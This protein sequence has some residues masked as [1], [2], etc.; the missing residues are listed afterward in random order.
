M[1]NLAVKTQNAAGNTPQYKE[2]VGKSTT[3]IGHEED[4]ITVDAFEGSGLTYKK[5]EQ[6]EIR[7]VQNGTELFC[8]DK[9]ELFNLLTSIKAG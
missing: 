7:I 3:F 2:N 1:K 8:G 5:R 4:F 9:H 6:P